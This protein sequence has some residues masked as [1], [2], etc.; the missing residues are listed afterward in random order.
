MA[1]NI[2]RTFSPWSA[3]TIER[4]ELGFQNVTY[5]CVVTTEFSKPLFI[6]KIIAAG[7]TYCLHQTY[8]WFGKLKKYNFFYFRQNSGRDLLSMSIM[9]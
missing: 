3:N 6:V 5:A 9:H 1:S 4:P 7:S 2:L 8:P